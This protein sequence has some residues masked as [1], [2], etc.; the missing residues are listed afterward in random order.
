MF[1]QTDITNLIW[2]STAANG[3]NT[4]DPTQNTPYTAIQN[5]LV[6]GTQMEQM[7]LADNA[8]LG[9]GRNVQYLPSP[10]GRKPCGYCPGYG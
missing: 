1:P 10:D 5:L 4:G 8:E 6:D 2:Y 9:Y 3:C 7:V